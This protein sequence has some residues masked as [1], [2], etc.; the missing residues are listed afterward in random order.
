MILLPQPS[1]YWD[2]SYCLVQHLFSG[3]SV[4]LSGALMQQFRANLLEFLATEH[5]FL[6]LL[7]VPVVWKQMSMLQTLVVILISGLI[8]H[9]LASSVGKNRRHC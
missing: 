3:N 8:P 5:Y 7:C 4:G 1:K 6:F 2:D 9:V